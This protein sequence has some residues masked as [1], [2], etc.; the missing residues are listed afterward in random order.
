M[1]RGAPSATTQSCCRAHNPAP[2][3]EGPP[4]SNRRLRTLLDRASGTDVTLPL[5]PAVGAD[6]GGVLA[7]A[8]GAAYSVGRRWVKRPAGRGSRRCGRTA[9][10]DWEAVICL[11]VEFAHASGNVAHT[12]LPTS[13]EE[14]VNK[15]RCLIAALAVTGALAVPAVASAHFV[16]SASLSCNQLDFSYSNFSSGRETVTL[17][18]SVGTQVITTQMVQTS[19]PTGNITVSPPDLSGFQGDTVTVTGTWTFDGGGKFTTSAIVYCSSPGGLPTVAQGQQGPP[20]PQGPAGPQGPQGPQGPAGP[21]GAG[22]SPAATDHGTW[23][24]TSGDV[25]SASH[26]DSTVKTRRHGHKTKRH[27]SR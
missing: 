23:K 10:R 8:R 15:K 3:A 9:S 19:G 26:L 7:R 18:W 2:A 27:S 25:R 21:S 1:P 20:G 11:I 13:K 6:L 4:R 5:S 17:T 14:A 12:P 16:T 24:S 22:G